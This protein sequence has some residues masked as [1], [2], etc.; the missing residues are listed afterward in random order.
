MKPSLTIR[1]SGMARSEA[2]EDAIRSHVD[3]LG[4]LCSEL[5]ACRATVSKESRHG[6][7]GGPFS[8]QLD[9]TLPGREL[10]VSHAH[11]HDA[12]IA[13]GDAFVAMKRRLEDTVQIRRG[14]VKQHAAPAPTGGAD[15]A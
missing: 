7:P 8:V 15:G 13:L 11:E 1:F 6:L 12:Y 2:L 5:I 3:H 4:R 10:V 9:V 14:E